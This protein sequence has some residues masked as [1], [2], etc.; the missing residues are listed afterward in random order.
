MSYNT[1]HS[2]HDPCVVTY[3]TL[4][5]DVRKFFTLQFGSLLQSFVF[6]LIMSTLFLYLRLN[7]KA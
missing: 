5:T 7:S 4:V 1:A 3:L 6:F 2:S